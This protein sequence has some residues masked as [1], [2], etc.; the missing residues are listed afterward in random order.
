MELNQ[1]GGLAWFADIRRHDELHRGSRLP[2][3]DDTR[4]VV[5]LTHAFMGPNLMAR[6]KLGMLM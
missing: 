5:T 4:S 2:L 3:T 6:T 1:A